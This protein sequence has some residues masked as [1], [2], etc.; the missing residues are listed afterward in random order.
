[1]TGLGVFGITV[2]CHP[3]EPA[4]KCSCS[5]LLFG[6][7]LQGH[8]ELVS[9]SNSKNEEPGRV[10]SE[11]GTA[12]LGGDG[13]P[14]TDNVVFTAFSGFST[15]KRAAALLPRSGTGEGEAFTGSD[16]YRLLTGLRS[17]LV[18]CLL[19][20]SLTFPDDPQG[21]TSRRSRPNVPACSSPA[22]RPPMFFAALRVLS[23]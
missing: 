7:S 18:F 9:G 23:M 17:R 3:T 14:L 22:M 4:L 5:G 10:A 15:F 12:I 1:M 8:P 13:G 2:S 6:T 16:D 20:S 11:R 19:R 21:I